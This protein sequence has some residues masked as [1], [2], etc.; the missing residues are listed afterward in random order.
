[1]ASRRPSEM[2]RWS[3]P[4]SLSTGT[5]NF[6]SLQNPSSLFFTSVRAS[7]RLCSSFFFSDGYLLFPILSDL[8]A[9][10]ILRVLRR[11]NEELGFWNLE[12]GFRIEEDGERW[13]KGTRLRENAMKEREGE[14]EIRCLLEGEGFCI[15]N[16][17]WKQDELWGP[18]AAPSNMKGGARKIWISPSY[19]Q[20]YKSINYFSPMAQSLATLY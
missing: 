14:M 13:R 8:F 12:I 4:G 10:R 11:A 15:L 19:V 18:P 7:G 20:N 2:P 9:D 6:E 17:R 5:L 3:F 1:M 16:R